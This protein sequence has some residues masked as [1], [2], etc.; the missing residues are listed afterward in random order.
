MWL[1]ID[2]NFK[3]E[4]YVYA[5]YTYNEGDKKFARIVRLSYKK[6]ISSKDCL[7]DIIVGVA[8]SG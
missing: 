5:A 8:P 7:E 6:S 1:A 2:P 4:P 3:N